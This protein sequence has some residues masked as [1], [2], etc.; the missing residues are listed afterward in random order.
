MKYDQVPEGTA[1]RWAYEEYKRTKHKFTH[2]RDEDCGH[3]HV[4]DTIDWT[5]VDCHACKKL[6]TDDLKKK[7]EY[8][9][10][11]NKLNRKQREAKKETKYRKQLADK[12]NPKC[13]KC[14]E[15]MVKRINK[16]TKQTFWGCWNW[17]E[18]NGSRPKE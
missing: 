7:Y 2:L 6:L 8:K 5:I 18:C 3:F 12:G 13:S 10:Y 15:Y 11:R 16:A 14:N 4:F 1:D 9:L 17:P